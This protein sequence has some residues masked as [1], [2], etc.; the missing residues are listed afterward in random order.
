MY[1]ILLT[2]SAIGAL[3]IFGMQNSDHVPVSVIIGQPIKIRL[4]F[5]LLIAA[6]CGFLAAYFPSI[7]S[8]TKLKK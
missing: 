2:A 1:K 5:L 4:I 6:S 8:K 3:V 7:I